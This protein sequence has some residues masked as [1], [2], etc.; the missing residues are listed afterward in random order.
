MAVRAMGSFG[1]PSSPDYVGVMREVSAEYHRKA[2]AS[3][4]L[5]DLSPEAVR[6]MYWIE[7]GCRMW[8]RWVAVKRAC[9]PTAANGSAQ[10]G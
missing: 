6:K 8:E 9:D 5:A 2:E 4:Q 10:A 3:R 1:Y 7:H